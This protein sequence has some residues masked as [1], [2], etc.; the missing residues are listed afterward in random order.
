M[1]REWL[2]TTLW[3][4][5]RVPDNLRASPITVG[6]F[7]LISRLRFLFMGSLLC[8]WPE[9]ALT[10]VPPLDHQDRRLSG[11]LLSLSLGPQPSGVSH[12]KPA[13]LAVLLAGPPREEVVRDHIKPMM[14]SCNPPIEPSQ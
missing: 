6:V 7:S 14:V 5:S 1:T 12:R 2:G 11:T 8:C 13:L 10:A 4:L 3:W 9:I